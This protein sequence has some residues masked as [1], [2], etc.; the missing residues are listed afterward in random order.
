VRVAAPVARSS[1][2]FPDEGCQSP[3]W[4]DVH[5]ALL[6]R[7]AIHADRHEDGYELTFVASGVV[8]R[9]LLRV[10]QHLIEVGGFGL[11]AILELDDEHGAVLEDD[12]VWTAASAP[13]HLEFE[14]ERKPCSIW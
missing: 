13:R 8:V 1:G 3:R 7:L 2:K 14:D 9:E 12:Q 11:H 10:A 5:A 6:E 4:N